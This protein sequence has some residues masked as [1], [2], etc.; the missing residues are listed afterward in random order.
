MRSIIDYEKIAGYRMKG[1]RGALAAY[2]L[3]QPGAALKLIRFRRDMRRVRNAIARIAEV[4]VRSMPE[5]ADDLS[6]EF[7]PGT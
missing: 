4:L 5:Q 1:R 3:R 2:F 7:L 6:A